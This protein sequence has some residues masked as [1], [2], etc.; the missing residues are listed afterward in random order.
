MNTHETHHL[1][2]DEL[3]AL[4][5]GAHIERAS[6]HVAN[7]T[8]CRTMV[9]LDRR[10]VDTLAHLS[11]VAPAAGFD[12]RVMA[13]VT[14]HTPVIRDGMIVSAR[15]RDARRRVA[16]GAVVVGGAVAAGFAWAATNPAEALSFASPA[17]QGVGQTLWTSVQAVAANA[18]EQPWFNAARELASTP[19]RALPVVAGIAGVYA[20]ALLGFRRLLAEPAANAGW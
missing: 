14:I 19:A 16:I 2:A 20:A 10:V 9:E 5:D 6:F 13:R 8:M 1:T 18:T 17:L 7:C 15:A 4:L 11:P 3:D 12:A